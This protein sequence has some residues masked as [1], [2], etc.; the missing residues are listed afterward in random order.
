[1][2]AG[3][4]NPSPQD[5]GFSPEKLAFAWGMESLPI[6]DK[7]G[8][9]ADVWGGRGQGRFCLITVPAPTW[10]PSRYVPELDHYVRKY[11]PGSSITPP[12]PT[13]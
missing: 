2:S 3:N 5:K 1:M 4:Q 12:A 10:K 7:P 6:S 13:R 8:E 11:F 9:K